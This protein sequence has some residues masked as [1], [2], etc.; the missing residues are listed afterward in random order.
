[1]NILQ[2]TH[3]L[4]WPPIDGGKKGTLGFVDGYRSHA[5]ITRHALL[6]MCPQE[7][8]A[9]ASEWKSMGV[10]LSFDAMNARNSVFKV[11]ANTVFSSKPF[12]MAKY[13]R[14]SFERMVRDEISHEIPEVVHFDSLHT[15]CYARVVRECAPNAIRVLRCHNAEHMILRRLAENEINPIKKALLSLQARRLYKYEA[16]ALDEFDLILAITEEDAERFR[17]MNPRIG[18]RI[19]VVPAGAD[20]PHNL[21]DAP[22]SNS[23]SIRLLHIAAMD[24]LPNQTGLLWF[25]EAILPLLD[26]AGLD[27]HLDVVGK[28]MPDVFERFNSKRVTVHG[29]VQDLKSITSA[30]HIA[31]VPL[32]VGGGMRVKILDYWALGIPVVATSVGAEGLVSGEELSV[33]LADN[34]TDFSQVLLALSFSPEKRESLRKGAFAKVSAQFSWPAIINDLVSR[35]SNVLLAAK[36]EAA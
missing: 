13:E 16:A 10:N 25:I 31:V 15:A 8:V 20:V 29:F 21:P 30:A 9:W 33:A 19:V 36:K 6:S 11:L 12:N 26:K 34:E 32:K 3:R 7:E 24:W 4:P 18:P 17:V 5:A 2:L 23:G 22:P 14:A 27:Y 35:Y 1:M 28:N